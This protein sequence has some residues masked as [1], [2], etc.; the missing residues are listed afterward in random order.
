MHTHGSTNH[1][2]RV[3]GRRRRREEL[4]RQQSSR[5]RRG[6]SADGGVHRQ[7]RRGVRAA[8]AQ[9]RLQSGKDE[10]PDAFLLST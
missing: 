3:G 5:P 7:G 2:G 9:G 10:I 4:R 6:P 8:L 1:P